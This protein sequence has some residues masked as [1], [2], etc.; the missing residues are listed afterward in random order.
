[1]TLSVMLGG[2]RQCVVNAKPVE[3]ANTKQDGSN[4]SNDAVPQACAPVAQLDRARD[5]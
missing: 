1:M 5:F 2:R 4:L 3:C